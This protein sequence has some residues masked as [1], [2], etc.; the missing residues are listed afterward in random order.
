MERRGCSVN[1]ID[2][3]AEFYRL[4]HRG[5]LG[6]KLRTWAHPDHIPADYHGNVMLRPMNSPGGSVP[7]IELPVKKA[8]KFW[9]WAIARGI[10]PKRFANECAPDVEAVFQGEVYRDIGQLYLFGYHREYSPDNQSMRMRQ[11][12][13]RAV[14]YR[15]LVAEL[16]LR[17]CAFPA[18]REDILELL[19]SYPDHIIEF[20]AYRRCVGNCRQRNVIIWEVRKY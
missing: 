13:Q 9:R 3:K 6:N 20:T 17:K 19:D 15:G 4:W 8:R 1:D 5:V 12:L 16:M 10:S 2:T 18:S 11:A 7:T 14:E